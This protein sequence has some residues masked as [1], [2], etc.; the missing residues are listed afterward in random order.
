MTTRTMYMHTLDGKPA[1]Y[2]ERHGKQIGFP[3]S[4]TPLVLIATLRKIREQQAA[5]CTEAHF[6]GRVE[7]A[8]RHRYGYV[9]VGVPV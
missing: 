9:R 2:T 1:L 8:N 5:V 7:W 6:A 4:R 3:S